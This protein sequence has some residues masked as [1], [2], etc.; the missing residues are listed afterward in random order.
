MRSVS[1]LGATGSVGES[2]FDLLMRAGGP[3]AFRTVALTG[4]ANVARLAGMARALRAEIAVTAWPEK[5]TELR[6]LLAGSGTEAAAGSAAV[7]EAAARP[8]DWTLSAIVGAAGLPPGLEVLNRGG[9]LALANKETLVAA[10]PLVMSRA[11]DTGA[12]IL[13]VDS[14]HSAIFQ[15]LQGE[16]LDSVEHVTITASG[17]AFRDWPLERLALA[18]VAEASRHPNWAMGQRITIDSASMFNK[19]LEVIEAHEF[20][21][22]QPERI[23]VLVHPQSIIHAMVTHRD[24]GSIAHLGAPDMRHAIGY[25]LNWPARAELPV[26]KLD[27]AALGSLTFSAP[28][29]AR[30]PAL[31]LAREAMLA[32]GASGAVLNAAKEQALD[33]FIAGHIRFTDMAPAVERALDLAAREPGFAQSPGDLDAVLAWDRFARRA[34]AQGRGAA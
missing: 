8:A 13:P 1:V 29:E 16:D 23:R 6:S 34:A 10:G 28:D 33:D 21:G 12:R 2:A 26:A 32:G 25:A 3:A 11:R 17:G 22:L 30:W 14:E 5:L 27:L 18:T 19:A 31:R 9:T 20:F 7:A 24:G 15:S 4:G